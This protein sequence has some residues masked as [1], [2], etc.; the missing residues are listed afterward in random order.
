MSLNLTSFFSPF[1]A[2]SFSPA[3]LILPLSLSQLFLCM[4]SGL[5]SRSD[6]SPLKGEEY[7][8]F[9]FCWS[10][11]CTSRESK[12]PLLSG[13]PANFSP[14]LL[15]KRQRTNYFSPKELLGSPVGEGDCE[16]RIPLLCLLEAAPGSQDVAPVT[17]LLPSL[18]LFSG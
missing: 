7:P 15:F 14:W 2:S 3:T 13:W 4:A 10:R 17:S 18:T 5:P 12:L 6:S 8:F 16:I 11:E 9:Q 1:H